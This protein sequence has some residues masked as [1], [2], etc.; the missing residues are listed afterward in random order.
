MLKELLETSVLDEEETTTLEILEMVDT[1]VLEVFISA[2]EDVKDVIEF[3]EEVPADEVKIL[4]SVVLDAIV[5]L[6]E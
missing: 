4:V 6:L 1:I 3:V 5:E 2:V